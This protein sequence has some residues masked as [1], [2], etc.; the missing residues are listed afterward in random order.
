MDGISDYHVAD[1]RINHPDPTSLNPPFLPLLPSTRPLP[2]HH[3]SP[4]IT[5]HHHL[6]IEI[7]ISQLTS[8]RVGSSY[9]SLTLNL[10]LNDILLCVWIRSIFNSFSFRRACVGDLFF[11]LA[12][13]AAPPLGAT[14]RWCRRVHHHC[15][16]GSR[17]ILLL[18]FFFVTLDSSAIDPI[19]IAFLSQCR[20]LAETGTF[21]QVNVAIRS[22]EF[23]TRN[24]PYHPLL[25]V[26]CYP[27]K[28]TI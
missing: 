12:V 27:Q 1:E 4:P 26:F 8:R 2:H 20:I 10:C 24:F 9:P 14:G 22:D 21:C 23:R 15:P 5:T 19:P 25:R 18:F 6:P 28:K 3:P 7:R 13:A 16:A 17:A 11:P